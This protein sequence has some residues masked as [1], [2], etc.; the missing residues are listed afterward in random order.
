MLKSSMY[1]SLVQNIEYLLH[2]NPYRKNYF[3]NADKMKDNLI[4]AT[5]FVEKCMVNH[6]ES[7]FVAVMSQVYKKWLAAFDN[8][9]TQNAIRLKEKFGSGDIEFDKSK[10]STM[11]AIF[12]E[13][14]HRSKDAMD[15]SQSIALNSGYNRSQWSNEEKYLRKRYI[16]Q[17]LPDKELTDCRQKG[18]FSK[19]ELCWRKALNLLLMLKKVSMPTSRPIKEDRSHSIIKGRVNV[20]L[21]QRV[22]IT[23]RIGQAGRLRGAYE[24]IKKCSTSS[25]ILKIILKIASLI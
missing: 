9:E 23:S 13:V 19:G 12:T 6:G 25:R 17:Q 14:I 22:T 7:L 8:S 10:A 1:D 20:S 5:K 18:Y 16:L 15:I 3:N 4:E 2:W 24:S 11:D 21:R